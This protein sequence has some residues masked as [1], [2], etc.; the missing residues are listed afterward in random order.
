M[1]GNYRMIFAKTTNGTPVNYYFAINNGILNFGFFNGGWREHRSAVGPTLNAWNHVAAVYSDS[2]N[3]VRL[4]LGGNQIYTGTETTS[5]VTNTEQLRIGIGF[6]TRPSPAAST[7]CASTTARS[8]H[9]RS[10]TT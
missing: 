6:P 2:A 1:G 9:R 3:Q 8:P 7:R 10:P 4:Y 5:L